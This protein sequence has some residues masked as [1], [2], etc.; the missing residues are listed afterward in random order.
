M[1][2]ALESRWCAAP[3]KSKMAHFAIQNATRDTLAL[4][5]FVGRLVRRD[6]AMMAQCA[7]NPKHTAAA[8]VMPYGTRANAGQNMGTA[9]KT[10]RCGTRSAAPAS[11]TSAAACAV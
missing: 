11:I 5:P 6:S 9:R 7:G 4:A 2:G 3:M 8:L 10:G 1:V